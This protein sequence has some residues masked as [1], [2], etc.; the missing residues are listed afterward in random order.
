MLYRTIEIDELLKEKGATKE[1]IDLMDNNG[2]HLKLIS[3]KKHEIIEAHKSHTDVCLYITDG[4]I[5][6]TFDHEE[7]C[8]CLACGCELPEEVNEKI[9]KYK[10][11]KEQ[12]FFF[13]KN[14]MHSI[15]ALKDSTF[16]VIK[17]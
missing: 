2:S 8:E 13:E 3:L 14:V 5:E 11:K 4:E 12:L 10:I 15:T 6:I 1:V 7:E 16:L 17:I 9:K